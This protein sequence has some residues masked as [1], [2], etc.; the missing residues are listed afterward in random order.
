LDLV[1]CNVLCIEDFP[2]CL[3][4]KTRYLA[5]YFEEGGTAVTPCWV[6][7]LPL[8]LLGLKHGTRNLGG[9]TITI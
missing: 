2:F 8:R 1:G 4:Y 5:W 3:F 6:D 7:P 9:V